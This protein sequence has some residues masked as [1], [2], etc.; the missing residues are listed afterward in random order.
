MRFIE[1]RKINPE[2]VS[3]VIFCNSFKDIQN[4]RYFSDYFDEVKNFRNHFGTQFKRDF[5]R[6]NTDF[7][8]KSSIGKLLDLFK[9]IYGIKIIFS[10][11]LRLIGL[12]KKISVEE[13]EHKLLRKIFINSKIEVK[14]FDHEYC[15]AICA[16]VTSGFERSISVTLDAWGD[17]HFSHIYLI[18]GKEIQNISKSPEIFSKKIVIDKSNNKKIYPS[19]GGIYSYFTELLGFT[20]EADEGKV[21]A[22]AAYGKPVQSLLDTLCSLYSVDDRICTFVD[23]VKMETL[24]SKDKLIEYIKD[25]SNKDI[26]ATVQKF[27]EKYSTDLFSKL[28]NKYKHKTSNI[29]LSGG[30]SA[31]VIN[32]LLIF[33]NFTKNIHITPAM[34][35]D[36]SSQGAALAYLWENDFDLKWI[37]DIQMP[38]FSTSY[39]KEEVLNEIKDHNS[40]VFKDLGSNWPENIAQLVSEGKIGAIFNGKMEW[41]PRALGNRSIIADPRMTDV[42]DKINKCIKDRPYFQPFCPSVLDE[43]KDRLFESCY[44]NRHMTCA[45]RM[46][47]EF[48]QILPGSIHIDGTARVQFVNKESNEKYYELLREFKKIA[49]YGIL[50]N[51]SFNKHGRTIVESPI[52]A[53]R[54]FL[55]T[56]MDFLC[57][58]G[59]LVT[60]K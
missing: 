44:F 39:L 4:N 46:K 33:E 29:V 30:V 25:N 47:K 2:D 21:E 56:N 55:D 54:D 3:E 31:N 34:G 14:F 32:N 43:E 50:I 16:H 18:D 9:T 41:G 42:R 6:K 51:T 12:I 5:E 38:Y 23:T 36:G 37:S 28:M 45:F 11:F 59:I 48:H 24:L 15:H 49:G 35:D 17:K 19:I 58:E 13:I 40:I 26:A 60:R 52:D 7:N 53:I 8:N 27:L 1:Y 10:K 22:L 57:I 20:P